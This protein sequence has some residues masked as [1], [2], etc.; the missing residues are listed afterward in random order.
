VQQELVATIEDAIQ[1]S[2]GDDQEDGELKWAKGDV[3]KKEGTKV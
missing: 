1:T 3:G 2:N